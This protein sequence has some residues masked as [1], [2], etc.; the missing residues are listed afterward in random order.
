[1]VDMP[2]AA[3]APDEAGLNGVARREVEQPVAIQQVCVAG[4]CMARH[5]RF[6]LPVTAKESC[7]GEAAQ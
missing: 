7:G 4:Q 1:M 2:A 6:F 3:V 5:Q